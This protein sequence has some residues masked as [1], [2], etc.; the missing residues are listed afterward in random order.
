MKLLKKKRLILLLLLAGVI[1]LFISYDNCFFCA[2][3]E[4]IKNSFV[5][6][7]KIYNG[8]GEEITY[9][10]YY[11][12]PD[13]IYFKQD[14]SDNLTIISSCHKY[15]TNALSIH[16]RERAT[17]KVDLL[18]SSKV[19]RKWTGICKIELNTQSPSYSI[20]TDTNNRSTF[21]CRWSKDGDKVA[22]LQ[23]EKDTVVYDAKS[24]NEILRYT[25]KNKYGNF[26]RM[27]WLSNDELVLFEDAAGKYKTNI[28]SLDIN[29]E[30]ITEVCNTNIK[31]YNGTLWPG[32]KTEDISCS[33]LPEFAALFGSQEW[34]V[35]K[36]LRSSGP[37][38][39]RFYFYSRWKGSN[40]LLYIG[41]SWIEGYDRKTGDTFYVK[42]IKS[43]L[44]SI[45]GDIFIV[46]WFGWSWF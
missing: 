21:N 15:D 18:T 22:C 33:N 13:A 24:G 27:E 7:S 30:E 43:H 19:P 2:N 45:F 3:R 34:P 26:E 6:H 12:H 42:T 41:K 25:N 11:E 9:N 10:E 28:L 31:F 5:L 32:V 4:L 44:K 23:H 20:I 16:D 17:N 38:E 29:T 39:D 35:E 8:I 1:G 14:I 40:N 36:I 46:D 37:A